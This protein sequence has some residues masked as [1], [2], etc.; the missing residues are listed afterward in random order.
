MGP[1]WQNRVVGFERFAAD[2]ASGTLPAVSWLIPDFNVS[3][4]PTVHAFAGTT[5]ERL[6]VRRGELDRPADQRD[7]ARAR[8][9]DHGDRADVG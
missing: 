4:H 5:H 1:L 3:E 2:A 7:H 8:L 6:G 9:A